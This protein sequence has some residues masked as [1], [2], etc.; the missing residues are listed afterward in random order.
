M[1]V[2]SGFFNSFNGDRRYNAEQMSAIF[3]GIINDGVFASVGTAFAVSATTGVTVNVGTGRAWFNSTWL[4]NDSILPVTLDISEVVLDR[5]DAVVIEIDRSDSVRAGSI[6][7]VKGTPSG[8][9][10]NPTLLHTDDVNQ[11]P[12]AY[13]YR[14]AGSGTINQADIINMV[15]S[16][17][18]PYITGLLQVVN[19]DNVVAQWKAQWDQWFAD[20]TSDSEEEA[21]AWFAE[22]KAEFDAWFDSLTVTLEDNVAATLAAQ[23]LDIQ[24]R[25]EILVSEGAVYDD[26]K[27][28]DGQL[29]EDSSG[30]VIEAKTVL[31]S[32]AGSGSGDV[33][34][35]QINEIWEALNGKQNKVIGTPG[36]LIGVSSTGDLESVNARPRRVNIT[37]TASGWNSLSQTVSVP[38]ISANEEAQTIQAIPKSTSKANYKQFGVEPSSQAADSLTFTARSTPNTDIEVYVVIQEVVGA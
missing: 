1:S 37:L 36:D 23:I 27:D 11:Y 12:L 6:K 18:C 21:S 35:S 28:S 25:F 29:I 30:S 8:E 14:T 3:N 2:T 16:S 24:Q 19:I 20:T 31:T 32:G 15:G 22:S 10:V 4:L 13:I 7:V 17:S 38:G 9:P 33:D 26:L 34:Q 5:I